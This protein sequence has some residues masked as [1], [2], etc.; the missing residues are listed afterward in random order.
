VE[1]RRVA[2]VHRI[3]SAA[4]HLQRVRGEGA[5]QQLAFP[6]EITCSYPFL[7]KILSRGL[8]RQ[9]AVELDGDPALLSDRAGPAGAPDDRE[10]V[11]DARPKDGQGKLERDGPV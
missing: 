3:T 6:P 11:E 4:R 1:S 5:A 8:L 9:P 2:V 10:G 7:L